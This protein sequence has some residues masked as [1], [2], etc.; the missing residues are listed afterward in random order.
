MSTI[1]ARIAMVALSIWIQARQPEMQKI[2]AKLVKVMA[3]CAC[4][5]KSG[6]N[7]FHNYKYATA[8]D[9]LEKVN[10]ALVKH[11][12]AVTMS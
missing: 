6:T 3:D 10:A 7:G 9:V 4:V 8:A 12:L 1:L 2:A 11:G 5:Q